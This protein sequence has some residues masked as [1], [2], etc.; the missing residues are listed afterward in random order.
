MVAMRH[1]RLLLG[2]AGIVGLGG[3]CRSQEKDQ[4]PPMPAFMDT[5][6]SWSSDGERLLFTSTRA[7]MT[8]Y[9]L[10]LGTGHIKPVVP[11]GLGASGGHYSPDGHTILFSVGGT[12]CL[13]DVDTGEYR[14]LN[15]Q[16]DPG[17]VS[18]DP[19]LKGN[20]TVVFWR[21][22]H[23]HNRNSIFTLLVGPPPEY[24]KLDL[25]V[26]IKSEYHLGSPVPSPDGA[27]IAYQERVDEAGGSFRG[28]NTNI[29]VWDETT[30]ESSVAFVSPFRLEHI[31]WFPDNRRLLV[32]ARGSTERVPMLYILHTETGHIEGL[33]LPAEHRRAMGSGIEVSPD[34]EWMCYP[35]S[36]LTERSATIW[37]S[38]LDGSDAERLT[39]APEWYYQ[40]FPDPEPI[41]GTDKYY[42]M[43]NPISS[44]RAGRAR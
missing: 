17:D 16:S 39:H 12:A 4:S 19:R 43:V 28:G 18:F 22:P 9:E 35:L 20:D 33:T 42:G 7:G 44:D 5:E 26:L 27:K 6:P 41:F 25:T 2:L 36:S 10:Q 13:K 3:S 8:V 11:F 15:R 32:E 24:R 1:V 40:R 14:A 21:E 29:C 38:R 23:R 34:G 31:S 30:G 37:R